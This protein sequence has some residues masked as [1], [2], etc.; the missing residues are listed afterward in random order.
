M[1]QMNPIILNSIIAIMGTLT[2][3]KFSTWWLH[4]GVHHITGTIIL[5]SMMALTFVYSSFSVVT[6]L[7]IGCLLTL[8]VALLIDAIGN[9]YN[10]Y[11]VVTHFSMFCTVLFGVYY[12]A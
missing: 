5:L 10:R 8:C 1:E 6:N 3:G 12:F 2:I 7:A 11:S 4:T 9:A